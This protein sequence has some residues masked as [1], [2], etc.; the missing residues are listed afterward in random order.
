VHIEAREEMI[1]PNSHALDDA[2]HK[3]DQ[4]FEQG[5]LQVEVF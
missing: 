5:S 3:G 1:Q 4:L 2:L